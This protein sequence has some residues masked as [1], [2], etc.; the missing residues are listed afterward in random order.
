M[1]TRIDP[2]LTGDTRITDFL[3]VAGRM[4]SP[5]GF[6]V[7]YDEAVAAMCAHL[8]RSLPSSGSGTTRGPIT[9]ESFVDRSISYGTTPSSSTQ[10]ADLQRTQGGAYFVTIARG[11]AAIGAAVLR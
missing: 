5:S 6:G 11:R 7:L 9:S 4:V 8:L 2:G 3:T 10:W 1:V